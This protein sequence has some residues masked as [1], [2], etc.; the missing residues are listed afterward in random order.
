MKKLIALALLVTLAG[1]AN[2]KVKATFEYPAP[3]QV[4]K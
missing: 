4:A 2:L 1:C 3:G